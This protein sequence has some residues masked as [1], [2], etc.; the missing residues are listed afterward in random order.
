MFKILFIT[1][2]VFVSSFV[3][4]GKENVNTSFRKLAIMV[5]P[6]KNHHEFA[7]IAFLKL[8]RVYEQAKAMF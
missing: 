5:H 8:Q 4:Q 2:E 7:Q 1:E 3:K 6:D